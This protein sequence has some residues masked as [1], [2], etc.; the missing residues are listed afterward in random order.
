LLI[1]DALGGRFRNVKV[2]P[3]PACRLC[4]SSPV[5]GDLSIHHA[6]AAG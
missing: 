4:G 1:Y 6:A 5:I 3:D 2:S